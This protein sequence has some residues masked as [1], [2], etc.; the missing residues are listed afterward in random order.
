M[1]RLFYS[2][3]AYAFLCFAFSPTFAASIQVS[4]RVLDADGNP[5]AGARVV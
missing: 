5:V 3:L 4:G 2:A 1:K